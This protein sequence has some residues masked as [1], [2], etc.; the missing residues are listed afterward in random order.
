[1]SFFKEAGDSLLRY[2]EK[3]VTKTEE[4]AKIGKITLDIRRLES[5]IQKAHGEIGEYVYVKFREGAQSLAAD[6]TLVRSKSDFITGNYALIDQKR[7]EIEEIRRAGQGGSSGRTG[8]AP[9]SNPADG[10]QA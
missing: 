1:M 6:D 10:P 7:G 2:T 8:G 3:I 9:G 5:Q 4:Y